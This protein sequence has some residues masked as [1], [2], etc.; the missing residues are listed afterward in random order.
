[1]DR[2]LP[3]PSTP[4]CRIVDHS[5]RGSARIYVR[6]II[7]EIPIAVDDISTDSAITIFQ[8]CEPQSAVA[9]KQEDCASVLCSH[10]RAAARA[11]STAL[12]TAN[13]DVS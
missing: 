3:V 10:A 1:M 8:A 7:F 6:A 4:L 11:S 5:A 12:G 2:L 9:F 13:T